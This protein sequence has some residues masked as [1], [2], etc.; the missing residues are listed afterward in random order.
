[1]SLNYQEIHQY[2]DELKDGRAIENFDNKLSKSDVEEIKLIVLVI[3]ALEHHG[4][5]TSNYGSKVTSYFDFRK[6]ALDTYGILL[7]NEVP[8]SNPT[9]L[10]IKIDGILDNAKFTPEQK[11]E[12]YKHS[13]IR[14]KPPKKSDIKRHSK[15]SFITSVLENLKKE[16]MVLEDIIKEQEPLISETKSEEQEKFEQKKLEYQQQEEELLFFHRLLNYK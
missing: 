9:K 6:K 11:T 15:K 13:A 2:L 5:N 1:M 4:I 14:E 16:G 10:Y 12:F 8:F 7:N 3:S